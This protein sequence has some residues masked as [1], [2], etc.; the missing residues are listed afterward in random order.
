MTGQQPTVSVALPSTYARNARANKVLQSPRVIAAK[1]DRTDRDVLRLIAKMEHPVNGCTLRVGKNSQRDGFMKRLGRSRRS[2][3][4]AIERLETLGF[5]G[6][7]PASRENG[8]QSTTRRYLNQQLLCD[9]GAAELVWNEALR[10]PQPTF[11]QLAEVGEIAAMKV[12]K[13]GNKTPPGEGVIFSSPH[14]EHDTPYVTPMTPRRA[15]LRN[16]YEHP[17]GAYRE[18]HE[19]GVGLDSSLQDETAISDLHKYQGIFDPLATV[20]DQDSHV[21]TNTPVATTESDELPPTL[22]ATREPLPWATPSTTTREL[23]SFEKLVISDPY[24]DPTYRAKTMAVLTARLIARERDGL[25]V[26]N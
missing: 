2:I 10:D 20:K 7:A 18:N 5:I 25:G 6:S 8:S 15:L 19:Q 11:A 1:L 24:Y 21:A 3:F 9:I 13:E 16:A 17:Q 22:V 12:R 4:R 23:D 14:A 26:A